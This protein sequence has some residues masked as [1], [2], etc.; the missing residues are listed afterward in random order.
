PP[1]SGARGPRGR[2]NGGDRPHRARYARPAPGAGRA[3]G[4]I[5][6]RAAPPR[7]VPPGTGP[8]R[9]REAC[10]G[11]ATPGRPAPA[12]P[13]AAARARAHPGP[14]VAQVVRDGAVDDRLAARLGSNAPQHP[15]QLPLAVVAA[16]AIVPQVV[17]IVH[18]V[19]LDQEVGGTHHPRESHGF[20]ALGRRQGGRDGGDRRHT[21]AESIAG[22]LEKESAVD[23]PRERDQAG[24]YRV[25]DSLQLGVPMLHRSPPPRPKRLRAVSAAA[26][27][28][29][30]DRSKTT[31]GRSP[32]RTAA[33]RSPPRT[34]VSHVRPQR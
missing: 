11:C 12:W 21:T 17:G 7:R 1:Q 6:G 26:A 30:L 22:H 15:E 20:L 23:T 28:T 33:P 24:A 31:N 16:R 3:P 29:I 18:L 14:V 5:R 9:A 32:D 2:T 25:D 13:G 34:R 4:G 19:G 8:R 10:G 27:T